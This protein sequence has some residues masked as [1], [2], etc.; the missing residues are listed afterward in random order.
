VAKQEGLQM[1][2]AR[3]M[4]GPCDAPGASIGRLASNAPR[5]ALRTP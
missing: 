3:V 1:I 4:P 5:G 2:G